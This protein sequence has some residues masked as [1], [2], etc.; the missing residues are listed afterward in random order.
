MTGQPANRSS[1]DGI[2]FLRMLR[3]RTRVSLAL[4]LALYF[5]F[6]N[7]AFAY[8]ELHV[9]HPADRSTQTD[10]YSLD[11]AHDLAAAP[12]ESR[13]FR[14]GR[15]ELESS[16]LSQLDHKLSQSRFKLALLPQAAKQ[17]ATS[18]ISS[19]LSAFFSSDSFSP[20]PPPVPA[21]QG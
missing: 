2:W 11:D 15:E 14:T 17:L 19:T 7:A 21:V 13:E 16:H 18:G 12:I 9:G 5:L 8:A 4:A 6:T 3:T 20:R 10:L 1:Y